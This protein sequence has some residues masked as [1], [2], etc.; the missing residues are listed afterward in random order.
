MTNS[1]VNTPAKPTGKST[2]GREKP[3]RDDETRPGDVRTRDGNR[4]SGSEETEFDSELP[5][6]A[7][8]R[9]HSLSPV[10]LASLAVL[11]TLY[12]AGPFLIPVTLSLVIVLV[13]RPLV[14]WLRRRRVPE[15]F[16]AA[17][18]M[19]LLVGL[20]LTGVVYLVGPAR[21]W[22]DRAP[23]QLELVGRKLSLLREQIDEIEQ[24][25]EKLENIADGTATESD[26]DDGGKSSPGRPRTGDFRWWWSGTNNSLERQDDARDEPIPVQVRQPRLVSGLTFLNS[27]GNFFASVAVTLILSFFLL[28]RGDVLLNNV[29]RILPSMQEKRRTVE[30]IHAVEQGISSY[31]LT[32]T[33]INTTL[34]AVIA[35][36]MWSLGMPNPVLWGAMAA[37]LNFLPYLGALSGTIVVF[38]VAVLS[39]DSLLYAAL[40]P[41]AYFGTTALEGSVITPALLGRHM[42]LNPI[43]VFLSLVFWTWMWGLAGAMVAVPIL[44]VGKVTCDQFH[45]TRA[46]GMLLGGEH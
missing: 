39:F 12:V 21:E 41:V 8:H 40:V 22:I 15:Y 18:L 42:S 14:R 45:R 44:A 24:A 32:V 19:T 2:S 17:G 1:C 7:R 43:L 25:S 36:E 35:L 10:V 38:L 46:I 3:T 23:Q 33:A 5:E 30:L 20:F 29:L 13:L 28:S 37:L 9:R 27:A 11:Y 26:A 4:H 31:L 34:G 6:A 16:S